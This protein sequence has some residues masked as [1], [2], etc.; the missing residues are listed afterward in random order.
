MNPQIPFQL[1]LSKIQLKREQA[2]VQTQD[3]TPILQTLTLCAT[4][5]RRIFPTSPKKV[6]FSKKRLFVFFQAVSKK[7]F[8]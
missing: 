6:F 5:S 1:Y 4:H 8:I 3:Y 7:R 2:A